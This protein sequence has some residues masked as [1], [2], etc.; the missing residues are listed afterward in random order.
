[1][2]LKPFDRNAKCSRC[3]GANV[4]FRW[5]LA[6]IPESTE[7]MFRQC[8]ECGYEW[9]EACLDTVPSPEYPEE[10]TIHGEKGKVVFP[11]T[12]SAGMPTTPR[13]PAPVGQGIPQ[14]TG[15]S[16]PSRQEEAVPSPDPV[17]LVEHRSP[18]KWVRY[19]RGLEDGTEHAAEKVIYLAMLDIKGQVKERIRE[20]RD[21]IPAGMM[22]AILE[23]IDQVRPEIC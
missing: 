4:S 8:K 5:A 12:V 7:I 10:P 6:S 2:T 18:E 14:S 21:W 17:V 1:M 3:G 19:W 20:S 23:R 9:I 22:K 11:K 13:P 16:E 15:P